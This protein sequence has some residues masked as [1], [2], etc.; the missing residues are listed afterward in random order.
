MERTM[1]ATEELWARAKARVSVMCA[2]AASGVGFW[3]YLGEHAQTHAQHKHVLGY[4]LPLANPKIFFFFFFFVVV[5][6]V[7][8]MLVAVVIVL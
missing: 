4:I 1:R 6:V 2:A 7:V 3:E 5:V 8:V